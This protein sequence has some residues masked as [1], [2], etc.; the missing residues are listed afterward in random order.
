MNKLT[1]ICATTREVVESRKATKPFGVMERMARDQ[2]PTRGFASALQKKIVH[3]Q[4][5]VIA[6]IKQASPSAGIIRKNYDPAAIAKAYAAGGAACLSVL[7]DI[8]YFM[9]NDAH[10]IAA[11][12]VCDL[13]VLRKD[14]MLDV[15]QVA[16]ARAMGAD[17]ILIIMAAVDDTLAAD[18]HAA[19]TD[20]GMDVLIES[21]DAEELER[22]L[23]LLSGLIGI[24]NR[25]L[26]TLKTDLTTTLALRAMVPANR[27]IVSE[28]GI[29][30]AADI[31]KMQ[32][33]NVNCFLVGESLLQQENIEAALRKLTLQTP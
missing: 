17:C 19:A 9:G 5:A 15:W 4:P 26:K 14:F 28:S 22:A 32:Q 2:P 31:H 1:E 8:K 24:N 16:E 21:H 11:R 3:G 10:L 30:T 29:R 20:F 18:L 25:N 27:L 13:P 6:E 7:T 23:N 33:A 12:A